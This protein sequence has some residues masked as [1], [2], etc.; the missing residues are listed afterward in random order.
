MH[1]VCW[2]ND[3]CRF[4]SHDTI[5]AHLFTHFIHQYGI[6]GESF[7]CFRNKTRHTTEVD[8]P[9][10]AKQSSGKQVQHTP[11]RTLQIKMMKSE[12]SGW[13]S[14]HVGVIDELVS[15]E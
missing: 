1:V 6:F 11:T 5:C 7:V 14:H 13:K 3:N 8:N 15:D 2:D 12:K 9:P 10:H 4:V